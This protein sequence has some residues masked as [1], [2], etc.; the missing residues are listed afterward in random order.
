MVEPDLLERINRRC[1][2]LLINRS[3]YICL[4]I[5]RD[6]VN[7]NGPDALLNSIP[8]ATPL[9]LNERPQTYGRAGA[10]SPS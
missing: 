10:R 8:S 9:A 5:A 2:Q 6:L 4:L 7:Q 3:A 1:A